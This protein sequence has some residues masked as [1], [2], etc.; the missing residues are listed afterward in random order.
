[1]KHDSNAQRVM[2]VI[3]IGPLT[4]SAAVVTVGDARVFKNGR[5]FSA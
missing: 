1:M 4:A 3:G 5:Q 2:A